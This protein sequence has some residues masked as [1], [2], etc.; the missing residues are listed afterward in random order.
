MLSVENVSIQ[1]LGR[2]LYKELS[3]TV[4]AKDRVCFAGPNGAGKSTL[5]KIIAGLMN[6]DSGSI[7]R[8]KY[9][10]VGYLPQDGIK[11]TGRTLFKEAETAFENEM[12]LKRSVD[13]CSEQLGKLN[14]T[15]P[16]Y[17][18]V[19]EKFG[20][21]QLKLDSFDISKMKPNIE[22]VLIGL[23]FKYSDMDR[24]TSEFSGGWQMRL[25]LAKLL[26]KSPSVLLLDEPTNHLDIDSQLW[27][28]NYIQSYQGSVIII[29]HD[30]AFL[31]LLVKKTL[32]FEAG[33]VTEF[34]GNYSYYVEQSEIQRQQ[35]QRAYNN[36][37]KDI[38][39]AEQFINRFR[40][41]A[42]RASQ[43]QSR[44]KQLERI[45]RI[46]LPQEATKSIKLEFP[47][48]ERSGQIVI[49]LTN[50]VKAYGKNVVFNDFNFRIDRG[51]KI[52]VVGANGAGKSTFSR[53]LSGAENFDAGNRKLGHKVSI[54][55][56]AQ[57][58]AEK[59]NPNMNVLETIEEVAGSDAA[60]N[61]RSLLGCFL[62]RGDDVFKKVSVLSGGER[63]RLSLAKILL[64]PANFLILDEPTNHL[65]ME[66]QKV[67]QDALIAYKGTI[68]IVSHNRD[69]LDPIT[70]KVIE[71][72]S[73]AQPVKEFHG[74]LSSFI[75]SR[76]N[77]NLE[78]PKSNIPKKKNVKSPAN[79][80]EMR[81][82]Q[83]KIRQ[84]K[85]E[86]LKPLQLRLEQIEEKI[87]SLEYRKKEIE[88]L[89]IDENFFKSKDHIELTE[90][91]KTSSL[92]LESAFSDWS[93]ISDEIED[94]SKRFEEKINQI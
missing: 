67:L 50:V 77:E 40:S 30:S 33:K 65:D 51:E 14:P 63:S 60:G 24:E 76:S 48:P 61:L 74:N 28:E 9:T 7:N 64:K 18:E 75:E 84:E 90:E 26:L 17:A 57:D 13:E 47:Q 70:D 78:T 38:A 29:S 89:M 71:F 79:R 8:A 15:S 68:V 55:H 34:A 45:E 21:L 59:L 58:H 56:F 42:R 10:E 69:F 72:H 20:E 12:L 82:A 85:S 37:Q 93:K 46:Q 32:A 86:I 5:M 44:L 31:D 94:V 87:E 27:L 80:K 3:F 91:H 4:S 83:G 73:D 62:F 49:E 92:E 6:P 35:I 43:A 39:K 88:D 54:S 41:K 23:G 2:V 66:S 36:Q 1:F 11:H 22:R 25:A 53:I 52:A 19:L 16:D 81:K